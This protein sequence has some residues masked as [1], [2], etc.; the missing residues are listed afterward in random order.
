[1][2]F[3][4]GYDTTASAISFLMYL[5]AVNPEV[6]DKLHREIVNVSKDKVLY[7]ADKK[8]ALVLFLQWRIQYVLDGAPKK[9][10]KLKKN[11]LGRGNVPCAFPLDLPLFWSEPLTV[12]F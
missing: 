4:G 6:Q 2:F 11:G 12:M 5:L 10:M 7:I 9:C 8:R 3:F 1:M